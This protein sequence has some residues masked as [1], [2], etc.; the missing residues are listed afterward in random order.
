MLPNANHQV[1]LRARP[2]GIPN[3][4]HFEIVKAPPPELGEREFLVRNLYLS[5]DPAMRGW[6]SAV[7][8]YS[9]AVGVGEVMR[10]FAAGEVIASRHSGY[11]EGDRVVGLFGW[12]EYAVS[13]GSGVMR[14]V[15]EDDLAL[16]LS[17]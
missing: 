3:A 13:D 6:V 10:A 11:C 14:K 8:N 1:R 4:E 17:L 9:Q 15:A 16:S 12:Q 2:S 7:A 5:V